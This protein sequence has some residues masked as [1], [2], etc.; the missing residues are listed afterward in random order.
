MSVIEHDAYATGLQLDSVSCMSTAPRPYEDALA[1]TLVG[2]SGSYSARV[3]G[4]DSSSFTSENASLWLGPQTHVAKEF[5]QWLRELC[6]IGCKLSELVHHPH[7]V[8]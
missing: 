1:D 3:V 8:P 5:S 2:A 6:K 4:L 7:E